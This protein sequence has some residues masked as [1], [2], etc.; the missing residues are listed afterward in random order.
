LIAPRTLIVP[1]ISASIEALRSKIFCVSVGLPDLKIAILCKNLVSQ[2]YKKLS[3]GGINEKL[4]FVSDHE[5]KELVDTSSLTPAA[6]FF[7]LTPG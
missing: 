4:K 1:C 6:H 5:V 3:G 7:P 2:I